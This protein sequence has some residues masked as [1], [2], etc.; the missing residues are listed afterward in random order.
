MK[1]W[2]GI[3]LVWLLTGVYIV[4]PDQQAVV[5]RFGA[6]AEPRVY[7]GLHMALPWPI[8][9]VSKVKVNQLQRLI[10]GGDIAD[11][12][13][14]R[15]QPLASQFLTGDQN[16]I[17]MRVAVQYFVAVP[18]EYLFR[19]ADVTRLVGATVESELTRRV[20]HSEVDALLTT[21]KLAVQEAA[22]ASAQKLLNEYHAGVKLASVNIESLAPP[23][24]AAE[25]FR[26]VA[27]ARADTSRIV[28]EAR[29]YANGL[30]P[31]ARGEANQML[32]SAHAWQQTKVNE[33]KGEAARFTAVEA[34]YAKA[35]EVTS[36]RL[37]VEAM[38]QVLPKI[39]KLIVD[40]DGNLDLTIIR[41]G[42]V[43]T[44]P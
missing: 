10:V 32:Q 24:E 29:G 7:P 43:S 41:K 40:P 16:I 1:W 33:A 25:A 21:E 12:A 35:A 2:I 15:S 19:T 44:T 4:R 36:N 3:A 14:G 5:T 26:D 34:E 27:S 18:A 9:R 13:M 6:I 22:L 11:S 38:E 17:H 37:Y 30:V 31:R 42:E 8:E 23:P 28:D 20:A 39:R